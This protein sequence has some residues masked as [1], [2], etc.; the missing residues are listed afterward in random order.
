ML[1]GQPDLFGDCTLSSTSI[2]GLPLRLPSACG[3]CG[4]AIVTLGASRG[5]HSGAIICDGCN[6]HRGWISRI[7]FERIGSFVSKFGRP[8]E[9]I[10]VGSRQREDRQPRHIAARLRARS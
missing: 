10:K 5:P 2:V 1:P 9:P 4:S 8:T 6:R 3:A 7:E